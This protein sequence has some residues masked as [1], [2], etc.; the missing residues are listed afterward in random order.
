MK[1]SWQPERKY[2][3]EP[4]MFGRCQNA[5]GLPKLLKG[6]EARGTDGRVL[7]N[8][9]FL[10]DD[11]EEIKKRFWPL[12]TFKKRKAEPP[13]MVDH[14][15]LT[16][17]LTEDEG[18][19]LAACKT[20][21]ELCESLLHAMLGWLPLH[22]R[23]PAALTYIS[24]W[25]TLLQ[26]GYLHRDISI[27]NVIKLREPRSG[28]APF[29]PTDLRILYCNFAEKHMTW[30]DIE[31][32]FPEVLSLEE[33]EARYPDHPNVKEIIFFARQL[34]DL[35][36][37]PD[38]DLDFSVCKAMLTDGDM[39]AELNKYFDDRGK[40]L[41]SILVSDVIIFIRYQWISFSS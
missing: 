38:L 22:S 2:H 10:P 29:N 13:T 33:L 5:F 31:E 12:F 25:L 11:E 40:G 16:Y 7:S 26:R 17:T 24:G 19:T 37:D 20:P 15:I 18:T 6:G 8:R 21:W 4:E 30:D 3:L 23:N 34:K 32:Q 1:A 35:L 9:I 39:A 27:G 14:R 41:G 28:N 36:N